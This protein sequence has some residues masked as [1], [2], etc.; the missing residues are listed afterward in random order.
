MSK[1]I[2]NSN[3][4]SLPAILEVSGRVDGALWLLDL[5]HSAA[6]L[7]LRRIKSF[8]FAR[9]PRTEFACGRG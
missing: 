6:M 3:R 5:S 2:G 4:T 7:R 1:G 9:Q 8:V